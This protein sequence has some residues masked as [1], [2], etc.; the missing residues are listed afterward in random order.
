MVSSQMH[1]IVKCFVKPQLT[2]LSIADLRW[3]A[4]SVEEDNNDISQ[5]FYQYDASVLRVQYCYEVHSISVCYYFVYCA[6]LH[7]L[8]IILIEMFKTMN[9]LLIRG[10]SQSHMRIFSFLCLSLS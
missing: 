4:V 1:Y 3:H 5:S 7:S 6:T 2:R 8:Y 10:D 9:T